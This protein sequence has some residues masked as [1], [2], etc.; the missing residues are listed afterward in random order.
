MSQQAVEKI[1][2]RFTELGLKTDKAIWDNGEKLIGLAQQVEQNDVY[3]ARRVMQ[4]ARNLNPKNEKINKELA[5][6][7]NKINSKAKQTQTSTSTE[8][9]VKPNIKQSAIAKLNNKRGLHLLTKPWFVLLV[10]PFVLFAFYQLVLAAP[11]YESRAQL[12]IQQPDGMSTMDPSM[13]LLSGLGV[14]GSS[15][16]D[17][18]IAKAY[19]HSQDMLNYL[20]QH[21]NLKAHYQHHG[22]IFTGLSSDASSED[23]L[24]YYIDHTTIEIDEDSGVLKILAQGFTPEFAN[25]LTKIIVS[26]AEWYINSIGHQLAEAQLQ[27][28]RLEHA[29]VEQ[30]L[31]DAQKNI[32]AFQQKNNL[33]DPEAEGLAL[34]QITYGLEGQIATK[35]AQL[36]GLR[37]TM[38]DRAPQV[39][40][41][42]A[43]LNALKTQL[44][45]ERERLSQQGSE[46]T[47]TT[48]NNRAVSQV[49]AQFSDLKI[50][51]ELALKGYTASE[52][53]LD[54]AR[55]EAYRQLKYLVVVETATL[56]QDHQYPSTLYNILLFAVL[57]LM[58]FGIGKIIL[59]TV[60]ELR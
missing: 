12:I 30:R 8:Q 2:Q 48:A 44:E 23:L 33:L 26:R 57:Q 59:A 9:N 11:R 18:E 54:K 60:K 39:V 10:V 15:T 46:P 55:I 20:Q 21:S 6:L 40:M 51:L 29:K 50:E 36:K 28:I 35:S 5:R 43:E 42:E 53:S 49:L 3:L 19:I 45:L 4:R 38:T 17:S 13:A 31:R 27:F 41:L 14:G 22:D 56:P 34:Q 1:E 7:T 37:S 47:N 32:L 25:N 52:V 24:N 16:A 58:L